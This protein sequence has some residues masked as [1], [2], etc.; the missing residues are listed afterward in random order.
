[1]K[2]AP[3]DTGQV[4]L[5]KRF[6]LRTKIL[7]LLAVMCIPIIGGIVYISINTL[8]TTIN[9]D[10]EERATLIAQF[11]SADTNS[12][13][14]ISYEH[15]QSEI[16]K[17][18]ELNPDIH[19]ISVYAPQDGEIIRI[20]STDRSQ[21]GEVADPED[22]VP[23]ETNQAT[24]AESEKDSRKVIEAVAP[25]TVDGTP[26]ATI[27]IYM[28]LEP[29]DALISDQQTKFLL[30]GG[31]GVVALLVLLY[32]SLNFYMVKPVAGL[33]RLTQAVAR[34]DFGQ[35]V[36]INS[37]DE[38]GELGR[39]VNRMTESLE[40]QSQ[41][42]L[43]KVDELEQVNQNLQSREQ[44]LRQTNKQ[45]ETANRLK[46]Q[47]LATMSHELRTPLNSII[48]FSELLEDETYGNLNPKQMQYV[49]NIVVSSRHLL[50]LINDILDLAKVES[51]TIEVRPVPMSLP[52]AMT[53]VQSIVEPLAAKKS[54]RLS[55]KPDPGIEFVTADP[56]RVKQILYNLLSNAIKFT[57]AGG[58]V[59]IESVHRDGVMEISV[60][61]TGIG[62][63]EKDQ[64]R[65]FSEFLQV[66][67]SY[68]RKY[69]GTGLGLAL[70]KKLVELHGG[71]IWV[72]SSPNMGSRFTFTIPD[73]IPDNGDDA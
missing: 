10:F 68:A 25:L 63:G 29:R 39:S 2:A 56:A 51:G 37:R 5:K 28:Y 38:L 6:G 32:L 34:G 24:H 22:Y 43:G 49:G 59:A 45:L 35:R 30:I 13:E 15:F 41:E 44:E 55:I 57:P 71:R 7:L 4:S 65:I 52:D 53:V 18:N 46:S 31:L 27:G 58:E 69:E 70:T 62:I 73:L 48:G 47:F 11:F 64:Q 12:K 61:D 36:A 19:K 50:Q 21:I 3:E 40:V 67:G 8:T 9:E 60:T 42:I 33:A 66:E 23:L 1:M 20:A 54:I 17:L 14:E 16:E 26:M 72:E